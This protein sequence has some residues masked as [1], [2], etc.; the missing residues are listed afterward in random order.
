MAM[1]RIVGLS[2]DKVHRCYLD[3]GKLQ[4]ID[5]KDL[6]ITWKSTKLCCFVLTV[7]EY[8]SRHVDFS[9][10]FNQVSRITQV[11]LVRGRV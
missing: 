7:E 11:C 2:I 5:A 6:K 3:K 9:R 10:G 8:F 4:V 1:E